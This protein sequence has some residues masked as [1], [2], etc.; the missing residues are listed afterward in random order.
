MKVGL[1]ID[2]DTYRVT[3]CGVQNLLRLLEDHS[4]LATFFFSVGPDNMGRHLFRMFRPT[5]LRKMLRSKAPSLYG[6]DI[7]LRGTL[8]PGP[9]IGQRLGNIIRE[10]SY[11]GHEIGLHAWDHHSW[12]ARLDTMS[13]NDI[14]HELERGVGMLTQLTGRPPTC[15]AAPSWR[16]NDTVLREKAGFSFVYNSDC[17]GQSLFIPIVCGEDSPQ[18][19]IPVTMPTYD[20]VIG[21]QG[22][23]TRTYNDYML[24]IPKEEKLNVLTVHAEAEG[25]GLISMFEDFLIRGQARGISFVPLNNVLSDAGS[26]DRSVIVPRV[27]S[28]REGWVS[29]QGE[30]EKGGRL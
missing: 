5:F 6:W 17:R 23:T 25:I 18:P 19:Q 15:S 10:T 16:C 2:V 9:I 27:I 29:W 12:Q 22:I 28:G 13:N 21:T 8:G 20:E 30:A 14:R 3:R 1:R 11:A 24:S 26:L 7:L 4:V